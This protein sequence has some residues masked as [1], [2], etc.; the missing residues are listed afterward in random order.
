MMAEFPSVVDVLASS[1][2]LGMSYDA[3][4]D[5]V[6]K[7]YTRYLAEWDAFAESARVVP[8]AA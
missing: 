4:L 2:S 1:V 8:I 6:L 7:L 3:T 5:R